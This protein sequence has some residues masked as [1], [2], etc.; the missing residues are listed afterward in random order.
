M[1]K[2][3]PMLNQIQI[4][5]GNLDGGPVEW[6]ATLGSGIVLILNIHPPSHPPTSKIA[7]NFMGKVKPKI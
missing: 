3:K 7:N 6:L 5:F 2:E 1:Y 4:Q